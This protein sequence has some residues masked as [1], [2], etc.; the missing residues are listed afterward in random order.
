MCMFCRS[1]FFRFLLA[2]VLSFLR[3]TDSDYPFG[4]FKHFF[5]YHN[6]NLIEKNGGNSI[7]TNKL[8]KKNQ[9]LNFINDIRNIMIALSTD[10][11]E[12]IK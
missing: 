7:E 6:N 1:L 12:S 2:I 4:I 5:D 11:F 9:I 3:F 10:N 8:K